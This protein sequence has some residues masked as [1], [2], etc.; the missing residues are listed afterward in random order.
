MDVPKMVE[1]GW[2]DD[3][4]ASRWVRE[5]VRQIIAG[6]ARPGRHMLRRLPSYEGYAG[7][8]ECGVEPEESSFESMSGLTAWMF[9]HLDA[10][11]PALDQDRVRRLAARERDRLGEVIGFR[12]LIETTEEHGTV[13]KGWLVAGTAGFLEIKAYE[14]ESYCYPEKGRWQ[15]FDA[16]AGAESL[17]AEPC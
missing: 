1:L 11:W 7:M 16:P 17:P 4:P 13:L 12:R 14:E 5:A 3:T 2:D 10:E 8:C 9:A 15:L 6:D